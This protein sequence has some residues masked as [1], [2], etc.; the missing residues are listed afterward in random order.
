M[1][2]KLISFLGINKYEE[3]TYKL[4]L[5]D[6]SVKTRFFVEAAAEYCSPDEILVFAT[7]EA[8]DKNGN[9]LIQTLTKYHLQLVDIPPGKNEDE[10]WKI[11]ELLVSKLNERDEVYF[12]ITHS[13]RSIP[14]FVLLASEFLR[15]A[16]SIEV[17]GI[18]YGAFEAKEGE[19]VPTF[20]LSPFAEM[21]NWVTATDIFIK[22]GDSIELA[23]ILS[24]LKNKAWRERKGTS[25]NSPRKMERLANTLEN[26]SRCLRLMR[27]LEIKSPA[28]LLEKNLE[29]V[30]EE[31]AVWAKPFTVLLTK[32]KQKYDELVVPS[33]LEA[34]R[35]LIFWYE[36]HGHLVQAIALAREWIVSLACELT[37]IPSDEVKERGKVEKVVNRFAIEQRNKKTGSDTNIPCDEKLYEAFSNLPQAK[38]I[39]SLWNEI[40]DLRNN[41]SHC[42]MRQDRGEAEGIEKQIKKAIKKLRK[43]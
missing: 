19:I 17:K 22:Y 3:T 31:T 1:K 24:K 43:V 35:R 18:L 36:E 13:F 21:L 30:K 20:D 12:D 26:L 42:G 38:E 32:V 10:L 41:V 4:P 11:F 2:K 23:N 25:E 16:K 29:E 33:P 5:S 37:N 6:Q 8:K 34:Q 40:S 27:P 7:K 9:K 14:I 28:E 15:V 39:A